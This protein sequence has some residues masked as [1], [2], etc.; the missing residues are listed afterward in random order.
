[1]INME[2]S[3]IINDPVLQNLPYKVELNEWGKITLSPASNRHGMIQAELSG[4]L[5]E[6]K[7][8]GRVVTECSIR[9]HKGVKVADVSWGTSAFFQRNQFDTPYKEAPEI[10]VEIV[11][12]SNTAAEIEEKTSLYL[13]KGAKEV[14]VCEESGLIK[15]Y[16]CRGEAEKSL[17]FPDMPD[18]MDL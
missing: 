2:W 7:K 1:M 18:S 12:P 11:S 17:L 9:T 14:W 8:Q 5:R 4:F 10:C 6:H 16:T 13:S 15:F 3:Q